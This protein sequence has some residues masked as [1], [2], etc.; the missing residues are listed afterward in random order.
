[1]NFHPLDPFAKK[2]APEKSRD[3]LHNW[4]TISGGGGRGKRKTEAQAAA[5]QEKEADA[6]L[7]KME[8]VQAPLPPRNRSSP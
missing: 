1:M 2:K 8:A 4:P 7:L 3:G 5:V 6:E